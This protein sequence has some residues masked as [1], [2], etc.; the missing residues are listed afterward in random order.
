MSAMS[1]HAMNW[2]DSDDLELE[3]VGEKGNAGLLK[4]MTAD[5]SLVKFA[6]RF[7]R[8]DFVIRVVNL[9]HATLYSIN[10]GDPLTHSLHL[11]LINHAHTTYRLHTLQNPVSHLDTDV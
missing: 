11:L 9:L 10:A 3:A 6:A 2:C 4:W 5:W 8:T 7:G 1:R